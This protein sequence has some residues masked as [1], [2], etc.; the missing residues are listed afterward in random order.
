MDS[1]WSFV[2]T[3]TRKF[4][5]SGASLLIYGEWKIPKIADLPPWATR[6]MSQTSTSERHLLVPNGLGLSREPPQ[7]VDR[8]GGR[9]CSSMLTDFQ[10]F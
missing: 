2:S 3:S 1:T 7:G 4:G 6:S 8:L 9:S 5:S 10:D